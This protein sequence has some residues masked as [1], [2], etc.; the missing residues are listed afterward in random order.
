MEIVNT[1]EETLSHYQMKLNHA[2]EELEDALKGLRELEV[3]ASDGWQGK[4]S[5][6]FYDRLTEL[7]RQMAAPKNDFDEIRQAL[8]QLR[9]AIQGDIRLLME[10]EADAAMAARGTGLS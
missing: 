2:E 4:A 7:S 6:A 8:S 1:Y 10:G 3:L 5:M 9:A